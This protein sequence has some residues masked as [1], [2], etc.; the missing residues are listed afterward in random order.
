MRDAPSSCR[1]IRFEEEI[2]HHMEGAGMQKLDRLT[3]AFGV[4]QRTDAHIPYTAI[5][6]T[7]LDEQNLKVSTYTK[8]LP[9]V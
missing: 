1:F 3:G 2:Y 7:I 6:D 9:I 4:G 5:Q 8:L